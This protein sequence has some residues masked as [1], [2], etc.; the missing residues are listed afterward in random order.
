MPMPGD[1]M[2]RQG[3]SRTV[4]P[5]SD[6]IHL[7][8]MRGFDLAWRGRPVALPTSAQRV[9]AFVALHDRPIRRSHVAGILWLDASESRAMGNLRSAL[10]RLRRSRCG[11]IE[12]SGDS[13]SLSNDVDLD[14]RR[15]DDG[16]RRLG[17]NE[18]VSADLLRAL[19]AAGE[20]LP[21][22]FDDWVI[23]ERERVRQVRLHALERACEDL[24]A[25]GRFGDAIA[26][27]LAAV[28]E[29]PLRESAH[30]VLIA[31][32]LAE[33]NRVE[34]FRQFDT[35]ALLMASELQLEP[36]SEIR[37]LMDGQRR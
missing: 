9:V 25:A 34:A 20:L 21:D 26:A 37:A 2:A 16:A 1:R 30:R 8:L 35:Y 10:W 27:G 14:I 13:L 32:H 18:A 36:S 7:G 15:L 6:L 33:G 12:A 22:W 11:V 19:L 23:I 24:V 29:E 3:L 31:A 17:Q 28:S 4:V 5:R